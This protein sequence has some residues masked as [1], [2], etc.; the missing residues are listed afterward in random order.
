MTKIL[1]VGN[2]G[3]V[4]PVLA[5]HLKDNYE[6]IELYGLDLGIFQNDLFTNYGGDSDAR[7]YTGQYYGDTRYLDSER[8]NNI[9]VVIAL[10][11][12]SNDPMGNKFEN[13]TREIN[14]NSIVNLAIMARKKGVKNFVFASSCS[15]YGAGGN[16]SKDENSVVNP[17]TAYA[18]SKVECESKLTEIAT[19]DF[20]VTSLRFATA[21][22]PS[23]RLRLDLVLNDFVV[24]A[25]TS[26]KIEILSDGTPWRPLID[27]RDM[28]RAFEW[29]AMRNSGEDLPNH[30]IVNA[31][32]ERWNY[33]VKEIA[34]AVGKQ[35][36]NIEIDINFNAAPDKRSYKV[37]F[38]YFQ[39]IAPK[40]QPIIEIEKTIIDIEKMLIDSN[41][42]D[43][44][45]RNSK[46]MRLNSI[47][48]SINKNIINTNISWK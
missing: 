18:I 4:G 7:Y 37:N 2:L 17:L 46:F 41:Y 43:A 16:Q 22:G 30:V 33:Q 29:A 9:D 35:I 38:K 19:N 6:N 12:I 10:A 44:N 40:Y 8:L 5:K 13:V 32:S 20:K 25:F 1:I 14:N 27:V 47:Q 26:K 42:S 15:V 48:N 28:A 34:L 11:A 24:S 3:Y 36:K 45:F 31:G 21:C 23:P 39:N